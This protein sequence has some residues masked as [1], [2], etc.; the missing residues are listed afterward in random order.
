[1]DSRW[2]LRFPLLASFPSAQCWLTIQINLGMASAT[3]DAYSRALV[4][5]FQFCQQRAVSIEAAN[6]EHIA[7]YVHQ[8]ATRP[9]T[10]PSAKQRIGLANA[11][12]QQ[13]L[14]AVR[15]FYDYLVEETVRLDNPVR[16]G[17]YTPNKGF[18]GTRERGLIPTTK[19]F[20]GFPLMSSGSRYWSRCAMS[21]YAT[22]SCLLYPT[23]PACVGKKFVP[24]KQAILTH[25]GVC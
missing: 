4:D 18:G 8:L 13:R 2:S 19:S 3:I 15:L 14:V 20:P 10:H 25:P 16:R 5:Y 22:N 17:V 21:P 7:A 23:M 11:T 9:V 24:C 6:R 1:M 12:M